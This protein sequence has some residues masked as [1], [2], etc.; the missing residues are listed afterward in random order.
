MKRNLL[1]W[2]LAAA[3]GLSLADSL[4]ADAQTADRRALTSGQV[5]QHL[6]TDRLSEI[7]ADGVTDEESFVLGQQP[8]FAPSL[9]EPEVPQSRVFVREFR[10]TGNTRID[11]AELAARLQPYAGRESTITDLGRA[12]ASVA[13]LYQARGLFVARAVV[14]PQQIVDGVVHIL[15]FE[16][17]LEAGGL[18]V[19][20]ETRRTDTAYVREILS[21][22][23]GEGDIIELARY[24]RALLLVNDLPGVRVRVR[25]F[26][27]TTVGTARIS[28]ELIETPT[29]AY[30]LSTDNFGFY[31]FGPYRATATALVDNLAG[32]NERVTLGGSTSGRGQKYLFGEF[33]LPVGPNGL[34]AKLIGSW[35]DYTLVKEYAAFGGSG[36]AWQIAGELSYP[37]IRSTTS[38]LYL[39][40][41]LERSDHTDASAGFATL[42][43]TVDSAEVALH[44]NFGSNLLAPA[45]TTYAARLHGGHVNHDSG[46]DASGTGGGFAALE[47]NAEH[48]QSIDGPWSGFVRGTAI[49]GTKNLE[50][51]FQCSIGGPLSNRGYAVGEASADRCLS[52]MTELRYDLAQLAAGADWQILAFYDHTVGDK[53]HSTP[54]GQ[55]NFD[56]NLKSVGLGMNL[57][58]AGRGF[59]HSSVGYQLSQSPEERAS[60]QAADFSTS[61]YRVWLQGVLF[62]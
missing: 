12:A 3:A 50:G 24:E 47:L 6:Q 19:A 16:G 44:G 28:V 55:Q 4:P 51:M 32:E 11:S 60:G 1:G 17:E 30:S 49:G 54:A 5:L 7:D 33:L 8:R 43:R 29:T 18:I 59:L 15:V 42:E 52:L 23:I 39:T 40:G 2:A 25:L 38:S 9:P 57:N 34:T 45:V 35:L 62:F 61:N 21:Q 14:P 20:N 13:E 37:L 22:E 41:K 58:W 10:F 56:Y 31:G 36:D 48:L 27:G 46:G 53:F 26:P